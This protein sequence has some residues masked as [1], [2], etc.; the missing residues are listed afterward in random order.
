MMYA[1]LV[2]DAEGCDL[3]IVEG[4]TFKDAHRLAAQ[5]LE[6]PEYSEAA[7]VQ[8]IGDDGILEHT[9]RHIV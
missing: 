4:L 2:L 7:S 3:A 8:I 9:V 6:D 1:I 5:Y